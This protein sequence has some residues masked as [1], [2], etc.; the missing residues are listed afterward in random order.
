MNDERPEQVNTQLREISDKTVFLSGG[1]REQISYTPGDTVG[2][3][4]I[5]IDVLAKGGMGV[6]F[7]ARHLQLDKVFALKLLPPTQITS[8]NWKR[9]EIEGR[10]LARLE[11]PNVVQIFNM[12]VDRKGCPFYVMELL[13]GKAMSDCIDDDELLSLPQF[14]QTFSDVCAALELAHSKGIV[15]RDIKPSNLILEESDSAIKR[16]KVVDFGIALL[17]N[18]N[19]GSQGL[20]RAGEV[21]GSP[22]YMSPEQ[23]TGTTVTFSSDIYSL[24]C[25]MYSALMGSPPFRGATAVE[26]M[27]MHQNA[28]MPKV[29]RED[30]NADQLDMI[31]DLIAGCTEKK[32]EDR[33]ENIAALRAVVDQMKNKVAGSGGPI[34]KNEPYRADRKDRDFA[35]STHQK[36]PQKAY[37]NSDNTTSAQ[38]LNDNKKQIVMFAFITLLAI[39]FIGGATVFLMQYMAHTSSRPMAKAPEERPITALLD[40]FSDKSLPLLEEESK[41]RLAFIEAKTP[42]SEVM[43]EHGKKIRVFH[44][45]TSTKIGELEGVGS[46]AA[47]ARGE[48]KIKN[49][50]PMHFSAGGNLAPYPQIYERFDHEALFELTVK[51][52][53]TPPPVATLAKWKYLHSLGFYD[54]K[55]TD[56]YVKELGRL[57]HITNLRLQHIQFSV[58]ALSASG[59]LEKLIVLKII[60]CDNHSELLR[61]L[62]QAEKVQILTL[63]SVVVSGDDVDCLFKLPHLRE[64]D[65][66]G[67]TITDEGFRKLSKLPIKNLAIS[68]AKYNPKLV[69]TLSASKTLNSL[70]LSNEKLSEADRQTLVSRFPHLTID[71]F[72]GL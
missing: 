67:S 13:H 17:V 21:F 4:Y 51:N 59:L 23:T 56:A 50:S 61:A 45:P 43:Q 60:S 64:L 2:D 57:E 15:H 39:S 3:S 54:S 35:H 71:S 40:P 6:L 47:S 52:T 46:F 19:N 44:F 69:T 49:L 29:V 25:T 14:L 33:F 36:S 70:V 58:V 32:V 5:L 1:A 34:R 37:Q 42:I 24:G 7:K 31:N 16:T 53:E 63:K 66:R 27:L 26:T 9:F 10:A 11:H 38:P 12:G 62:A 28:D 22:A 30:L 72:N 20:T 68:L 55:L 65:L 41:V 8:T 18:Q 48:I